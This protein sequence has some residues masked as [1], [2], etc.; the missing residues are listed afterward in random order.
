M[1][2]SINLKYEKT[3]F[4]S[5]SNSAFIE[6]MYLR[7]IKKDP[8]LP[9]SWKRYFETLDDDIQSVIKEIEGPTWNP[10][11]KKVNFVMLAVGWSIKNTVDRAFI[12]CSQ[13]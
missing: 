7:F 1:S 12:F 11:K 8:N 4:L 9:D 10:K 3:S 6:E 13:S 2:S 5:K